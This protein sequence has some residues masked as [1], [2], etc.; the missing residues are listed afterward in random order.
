M[1]MKLLLKLAI[2][3]LNFAVWR[4]SSSVFHFMGR[5]NYSISYRSVWSCWIEPYV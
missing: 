3:C 5:R 4:F 2:V 1:P